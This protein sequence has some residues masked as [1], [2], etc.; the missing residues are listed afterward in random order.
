[1]WRIRLL[2]LF[3]VLLAALVGFLHYTDEAKYFAILAA[4][5]SGVSGWLAI[6][7]A[8]EEP[9]LGQKS[10]ALTLAFR[11]LISDDRRVAILLL[12]LAVLFQAIATV[13]GA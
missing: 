2:I 9:R 10:G 5:C 1:M 6:R 7:Q 3:V 11:K 12:Q 8:E 4:A 13:I